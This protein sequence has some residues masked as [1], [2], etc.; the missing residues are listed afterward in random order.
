METF[1]KLYWVFGLLAA[2]GMG[3]GLYILHPAPNFGMATMAIGTVG[4]IT[5]AIPW[6]IIAPTEEKEQ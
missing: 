3:I 4:V 2:V 6:L 1:R 5:C